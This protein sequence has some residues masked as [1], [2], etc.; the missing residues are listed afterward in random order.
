ML[1]LQQ[2]QNLQMVIIKMYKVKNSLT[3]FPKDYNKFHKFAVGNFQTQNPTPVHMM[4][5]TSN[6]LLSISR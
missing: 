5:V 2:M 3:N 4:L 1:I 6:K